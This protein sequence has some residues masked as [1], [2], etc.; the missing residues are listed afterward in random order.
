MIVVG[1][2]SYG[3]VYAHKGEFLETQFA[4]ID[5]LPLFP[6]GSQWITQKV[7]GHRVGFPV[8]L[9][10]KSVAAGYLRVWGVGI[11][12]AM[13][14]AGAIVATCVAAA[15]VA[16]SWTWRPLPR[17]LRRA[18]DFNRVAFASRC[19]PRWMKRAQRIGNEE[20]LRKSAERH[21]ARAPE[22]VARFGAKDATEAAIAYGL[23]RLAAVEH[24]DAAAQA[25]RI[26]ASAFE[27]LTTEAGPYREAPPPV[28]GAFGAEISSAAAEQARAAR[29]VFAPAAK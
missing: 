20:A 25:E 12:S 26:L 29:L 18:S 16:W 24:R 17:G 15:L 19:E 21:G 7:G 9:N 3:R 6:I 13:F 1:H 27:P 22:D 10:L 5:F 8:R 23:L 14:A 11:T 4:H 2:R 28:A